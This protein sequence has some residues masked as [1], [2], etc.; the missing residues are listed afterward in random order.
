MKLSKTTEV[1]AFRAAV[2]ACHGDVWLESPR[3]DRYN[4]K[5]VFS[6]CIALDVLLSQHGDELELYCALQE[7]EANFFKFFHEHPEVL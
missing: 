1:N 5:S 4:L 6:Q 3:G 7:D 2:D